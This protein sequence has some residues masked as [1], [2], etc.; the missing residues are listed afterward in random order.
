MARNLTAGYSV[1]WNLCHDHTKCTA[2]NHRGPGGKYEFNALCT[3]NGFWMEEYDSN[4]SQPSP[5][6][7]ADL[8]AGNPGQPAIW[9]EDQGWFDQWGVAKRVRD[10]S[11]QIYGVAR[12][13]A[14]GGSWHNF[15]MLTGGNNYGR[16]AGGDVVT[17]YAPDTAIDNFFLRHEPRYAHYRNFF[18]ALQAHAASMLAAPLAPTLP[19]T[20]KQGGADPHA[21]PRSI[22]V[23][24][25]VNNNRIRSDVSR[26][27]VSVAHCSDDD[28]AHVGQLDKT[29]QWALQP[30]GGALS[31]VVGSD[32][33]CATVDDNSSTP[34]RL[35]PCD[36]TEA[37]R[38]RFNGTTQ[39][40]ESVA[41]RACRKK[42]RTG[43]CQLCVDLSGGGDT[44][45]LWDC[46]GQGEGEQAN[47]LWDTSTKAV[48]HGIIA[49]V[50]GL[51][52][53]ATP[54]A[55]T[56]GPQLHEYGSLA[57][58]S[59]PEDL[60]TDGGSAASPCVVSYGGRDYAHTAPLCS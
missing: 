59:N 47:Q 29:Q 7:L 12:F 44:V 41:R 5:K 45:D 46:K 31:V 18:N 43:K 28:P 33:W 39:H 30:G 36:Q 38:F 57:F 16:Q 55:A 19:L 26:P 60:P 54:P 20:C 15:Y 2:I 53:T 8:R 3:I 49:A 13:V 4:P 9:T 22:T 17:G 1:P 23:S 37:Q 11:D 56:A 32:S 50:S 42:G 52:L 58:L 10:S 40:I 27:T 35:A 25:T 14:F 6:W 48:E 34:L 24:P 51:C 21:P